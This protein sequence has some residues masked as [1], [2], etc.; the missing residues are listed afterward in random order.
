M[1]FILQNRSWTQETL[2]QGCHE[3]GV[4]DGHRSRL[5]WTPQKRWTQETLII[6]RFHNTEK[7]HEISLT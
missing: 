6:A 2:K 3:T 7:P 1:D 5:N 4:A